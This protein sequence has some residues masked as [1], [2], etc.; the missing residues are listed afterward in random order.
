MIGISLKIIINPK[1]LKK[2][3]FLKFLNNNN[4][5]NL[6]KIAPKTNLYKVKKVIIFNK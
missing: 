4:N 6:K 3:K 5:K 1:V 2:V